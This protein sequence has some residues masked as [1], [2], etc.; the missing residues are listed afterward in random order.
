MA[1]A[2]RMWLMQLT[3]WPCCL[4]Q[5]ISTNMVVMVGQPGMGKSSL[6]ANVARY[7]VGSGHWAEA[8]WVDMQGVTSTTTAAHQLAAA[9]GLHGDTPDSSRY[10]SRADLRCCVC[11][12]GG[13]CVLCCDV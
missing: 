3:Q 7:L 6:A 10:G 12:G 2:C 11:G 13:V 9:L 1:V 8:Y 4:P 5:D